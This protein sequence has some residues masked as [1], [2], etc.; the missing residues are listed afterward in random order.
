MAAPPAGPG[1]GRGRGARGYT[2]L[3]V[4]HFSGS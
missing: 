4:S 2:H 1:S 3:Q